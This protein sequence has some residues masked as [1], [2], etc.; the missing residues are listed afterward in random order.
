MVIKKTAKASKEIKSI[1][2][3]EVKVKP[4]LKVE[5]KDNPELKMPKKPKEP[6]LVAAKVK[7]PTTIQE[8][9]DDINTEIATINPKKTR[10]GKKDAKE[11]NKTPDKLV[12]KRDPEATQKRIMEAAIRDFSKLGFGGARVDRIALV[13]K[14]NERML[15]YYFGSKEGL[16][17]AVLEEVFSRYNE[18]EKELHLDN[19]NPIEALK[20]LASFMWD[21]Y[22]YH[23]EFIRLL[24]SENLHEAKHIRQSTSLGNFIHPFT[25]AIKKILSSGSN[26]GLMRKD[27][28]PV[29]FYLTIS[30]LGYYILSNRFTLSAVTGREL[31]SKT[32][33]EIMKDIHLDVLLSYISLPKSATKVI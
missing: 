18:A 33:Y 2:D 13:A 27:I 25:E 1:K 29:R 12:R 8:I 3:S 5:A 26:L 24:N 22:Y 4:N 32:E 19:N 16:F 6:K 11:T 14:T 30:S 23:P 20:I 7:I 17:V 21:Y 15:Y 9:T 31:M 10:I 28:D